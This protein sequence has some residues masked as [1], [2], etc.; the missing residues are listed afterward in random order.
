MVRPVC[1]QSWGCRSSTSVSG[2]SGRVFWPPTDDC[3]APRSSSK[4]AARTYY[5]SSKSYAS[6]CW[7]ALL[8]CHGYAC[9]Y[10]QMQ[11][12]RLLVCRPLSATAQV[13]R[14][15]IGLAKFTAT[16]LVQL[17]QPHLSR[18]QAGDK[19]TVAVI[20]VGWH[21]KARSQTASYL[22]ALSNT[23]LLKMIMYY[24]C[25]VIFQNKL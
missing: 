7:F 15:W 12:F 13:L 14:P 19:T 4:A 3:P 16:T 18:E 21:I 17:W 20:Y 10:M 9:I 6:H 11:G 8:A 22:A 2:P 23:F 24:F 25:E 5:T 1:A